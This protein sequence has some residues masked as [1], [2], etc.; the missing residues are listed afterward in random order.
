MLD[1]TAK[2]VEPSRLLIIV[3]IALTLASAGWFFVVGPDPIT[4]DDVR[5]TTSSRTLEAIGIDKIARLNLFGRA[6]V[7]AGSQSVGR[8]DAPETSLRLE[9]VGIFQA[10]E[11]EGSS[12]I[13][14]EQGRPAE[15]YGIGD[16][17]PGNAELVEVYTDRVVLRRGGIYETLR[18]DDE[19]LIHPDTIDEI[20]QRE[21]GSQINDAFGTTDQSGQQNAFGTNDQSAQQPRTVREFVDTYRERIQN[22]P[23]MTLNS[24]GLKPVSTT[25]AKGY[26][27]GKLADSPY[28]S[29][30][31]LQAG[32]VILSVNGRPVGNAGQDRLEIDNIIAQGSARLEVQRG[33]RRFFVTASLR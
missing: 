30:T 12:A 21:P 18:F 28:L 9:L 20:S 26:K 7:D 24:L 10:D 14:S 2:L 31:G 32:D 16:R 11:P 23:Q 5:R 33:S 8:S 19:R 1:L 3:G 27:L 22:D 6:D 15:L 13:I 25:E 29:Q 4:L 17:I